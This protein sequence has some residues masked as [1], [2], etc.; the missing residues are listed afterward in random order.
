MSKIRLRQSMRIFVKNDPAKFH[1][2]PI[3][4]D[5]AL[6]FSAERRPNKNKMSS[7]M[8]SVLDLKKINTTA[9]CNIWRV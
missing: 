3:Q 6:G 1:P 7:D 9:V 2:G 8:R 4:N 5:K